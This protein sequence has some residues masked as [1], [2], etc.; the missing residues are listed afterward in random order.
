MILLAINEGASSINA[1]IAENVVKL[2]NWQ[3]L[4]RRECD[5]IDAETNVAKVEE[6]ARRALSKGPLNPRNLKIKVNYSRYGIYIFQL[7]IDNLLKEKEIFLDNKAN[8][9]CLRG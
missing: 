4:I 7:A 3:L 8:L 6:L 5:V 2:L 9:Y 1:Q